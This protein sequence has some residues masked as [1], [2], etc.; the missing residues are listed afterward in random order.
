MNEKVNKKKAPA[1]PVEETIDDTWSMNLKNITWTFSTL[2]EF[3]MVKLFL[4]FA[5]KHR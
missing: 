4:S 3:I 2:A 5:S 1:E